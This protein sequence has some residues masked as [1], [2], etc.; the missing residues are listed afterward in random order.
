MEDCFLGAIPLSTRT[1]GKHSF[2]C[3]PSESTQ[4]LSLFR[5]VS[6]SSKE[7]GIGRCVRSTIDKRG[8]LCSGMK[9]G[10]DDAIIGSVDPDQQ[11]DSVIHHRKQRWSKNTGEM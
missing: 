9:W 8:F 6:A 2:L 4:F 7:A 5:F 10:M 11:L 1:V 3:S